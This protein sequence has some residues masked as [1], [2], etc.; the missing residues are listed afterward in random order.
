M[1]R[2]L[3]LACAPPCNLSSGCLN[4][5]RICEALPQGSVAT[6]VVS[7][8]FHNKGP[9]PSLLGMPFHTRKGPPFKVGK[10][11]ILSPLASLAVDL[12]IGRPRLPRL[13]DDIVAFAR[14][15][16]IEAVWCGLQGHTMIRLALPVA[17]QLGVPLLS[18][19]W[20]P[21][22]WWLR[23]H[24]LH[25]YSQKHVLRQFGRTLAA[26]QCIGA[27]SEPMA[28]E[29]SALYGAE[30][31]PL[32]PFLPDSY[33]VGP[34]KSKQDNDRLTIGIAGQLY[35]RKE[36]QALLG[37]L[38]RADWKIGAKQVVLAYL[39]IN[40]IKNTHPKA[41]IVQLGNQ[42]QRECIRT[43]SSFDLLYCP[44]WF[45]PVFET[46]ARLSFPSKLVSYL[47]A[48]R[49]VFFHGPE[50]SSPV[51]FV[52]KH[53]LGQCCHS[54]N[55]DIVLRDLKTV[56]ARPDLWTCLAK[57]AQDAFFAHLSLSAQKPNLAKFF[58][59]PA[60]RL[61]AA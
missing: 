17:E 43:L 13:I 27:A 1:R 57:N 24:R 25:P 45:N 47:A 32:I 29:Y 46:E 54:L 42:E 60:S 59:V 11:P 41:R 44:Y 34:A 3:L 33:Q 58:H 61:A 20:D 50:Y 8:Y 2:T 18:Q 49:P 6:Y 7:D 52:N 15:H 14:R 12:A 9:S 5:A 53:D 39:G 21:P 19:I 51:P 16:A 36:M 48:S 26:S 55:P 23:E 35:A 40:R 4:L 38:D 22:T 30:A 10:F 37:A 28:Q 56:L 31:V